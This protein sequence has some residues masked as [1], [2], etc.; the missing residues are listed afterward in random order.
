MA[1]VRS[2]NNDGI[3][4]NSCFIQGA[5]DLSCGPIGF[6][7]EIANRGY[8]APSFEGFV[9]YDR[10]VRR[11]HGKVQ[12]EGLVPFGLLMNIYLVEI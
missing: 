8:A 9:G 10:R 1:I 4:G 11:G 7:Q 12:K 3:V 2:E 5:D 6:Y